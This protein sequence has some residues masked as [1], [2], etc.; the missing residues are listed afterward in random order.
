M[1][2]QNGLLGA[3]KSEGGLYLYSGAAPTAELAGN[4]ITPP[5]G[6]SISIVVLAHSR[7]LGC[8]RTFLGLGWAGW[9]AGLGWA[10]Y[11]RLKLYIP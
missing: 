5:P 6:V 10:G 4:L 3:A 9:L 2:T 1:G 8:I 11:V 7:P